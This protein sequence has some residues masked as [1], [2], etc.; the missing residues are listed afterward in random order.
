MDKLILNL[1]L[2]QRVKDGKMCKINQEMLNNKLNKIKTQPIEV[3]NK[4]EWEVVKVRHIVDLLVLELHL[5]KMLKDCI[6]QK[7]L[8]PKVKINFLLINKLILKV[9]LILLVVKEEVHLKVR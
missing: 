4:W 6:I 9:E 8:N 7:I 5:I 2:V 1:D 3:A